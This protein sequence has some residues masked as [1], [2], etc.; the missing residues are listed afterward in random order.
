MTAKREKPF[1]ESMNAHIVPKKTAKAAV[2]MTAHGLQTLPRQ[3][4]PAKV[5]KRCS[6]P[7][8]I[9]IILVEVT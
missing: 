3:C 7:N 2:A 4:L 9:K 1:K 5:A 6:V 8:L